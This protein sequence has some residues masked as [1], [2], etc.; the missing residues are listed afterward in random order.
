MSYYKEVNEVLG[1]LR[2]VPIAEHIRHREG[3]VEVR[4]EGGASVIINY[5]DQAVTING[6]R[7]EAQHFAAGGDGA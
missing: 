6:V 3:V 7:V 5:T 2:N 4:Y 1:P